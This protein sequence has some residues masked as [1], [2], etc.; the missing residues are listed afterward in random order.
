[1]STGDARDLIELRIA[2]KEGA[3]ELVAN[4]LGAS[5]NKGL[6]SR[7]TLVWGNKGSFKLEYAGKKRAL[8]YDFKAGEAGDLLKLIRRRIINNSFSAAVLWARNWQGWARGSQ[9]S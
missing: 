2:L 3:S 8:W 4:V 1:M 7:R 6:S 5:H 9:S